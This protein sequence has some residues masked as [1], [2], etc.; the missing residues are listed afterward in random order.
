M[1][2]PRRQAPLRRRCRFTPPAQPLMAPRFQPG[3]MPIFQPKPPPAFQATASAADSSAAA[4]AMFSRYFRAISFR[5]R[6]FLLR[7]RRID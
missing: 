6:C 2:Q 1:S 7:R 5:R 4:A 3:R